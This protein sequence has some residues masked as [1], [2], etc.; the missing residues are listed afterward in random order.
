M[1]LSS[2]DNVNL[3]NYFLHLVVSPDYSYGYKDKTYSPVMSFIPVLVILVY[4]VYI[5]V[6][7]RMG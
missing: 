6:Y 3:P 7:V 1:Y 2:I 4:N 5:N